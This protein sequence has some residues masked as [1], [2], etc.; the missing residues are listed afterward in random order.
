[1]RRTELDLCR[2]VACVMVLFVHTGAEAFYACPIL[3]PDF[4]PLCLIST[5]VRGS[6]P[7]FFMLSGAL[8]LSRDRLDVLPFLKKHALYLTGMFFLWSLLYALGS[9]LAA[10]SFGSLY[11][12]FFD[13]AQGHYHLWFLPAMVLCY[14]FMPPV[15]SALHGE[16]LDARYLLFLFF[17]LGI[18]WTNFN[19]T[20]DPAYILNRLTLDLSL[21]YLPYLGY[22]VWGYWL[23]AKSF[24]RKWL[25]IAPAV[26]IAVTV[27]AAFG[28][29]WYSG[30]KGEADGWLFSYFSLPSF[31]QA[32]AIFCFFRALGERPLRGGRA[33]GYLSECTLGVYLIH[34]L[35]INV[36]Q[37]LGYSVDPSR[38]VASLLVF[39]LA[40]ALT[41]FALT[42]AAKRLPV[43][44]KLL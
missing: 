14:L 3:S 44:R 35:V 5:A 37:R 41:C 8:L 11:A 25:Y 9:R 10:G 6:V 15:W 24:G 28:N 40:L 39:T 19:L 2:I 22:A 4:F 31:L 13:V 7:V 23:S 1:M 17:L 20:P 33:L 12:F 30:Y 21:E 18:L 32:S 29:V 42:A 16:R 38:P 36:F 43:I 26:Y 34:P 27:A